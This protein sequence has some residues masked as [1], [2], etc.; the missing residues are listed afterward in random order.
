MFYPI[1][2]IGAMIAIKN[3]KYT[4]HIILIVAFINFFYV[5]D[6]FKQIDY[7]RSIIYEYNLFNTNNNLSFVNELKYADLYDSNNTRLIEVPNNIDIN[8]SKP[9]ILKNFCFFYHYPD[10][11][12]QTY[13]EAIIDNKSNLKIS[14][15]HFMSHPAYTFEY[16]TKEGRKFFKEKKFKIEV[17]EVN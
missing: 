13:H 14:K 7:P 3:F 2:I 12:M 10:N 5:I 11:F 1:I 8:H 4:N 6:E 9:L 15:N 17:Y 16:C